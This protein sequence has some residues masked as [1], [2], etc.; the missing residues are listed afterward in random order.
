MHSVL[1]VLHA[2]M[3]MKADELTACVTQQASKRL[4]HAPAAKRHA[5]SWAGVRQGNFKLQL[6]QGGRHQHMH[7]SWCIAWTAVASLL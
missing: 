4:Q 3:L 5:T 1:C 6:I 2:C 7:C